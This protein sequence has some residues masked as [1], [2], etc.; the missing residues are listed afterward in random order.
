MKALQIEN[1]F[2]NIDIVYKECKKLKFYTKEE[3]PQN[4]KT[5][6]TKWPGKRTHELGQC[7]PLLKYF[8]TKYY[9][10]NNLITDEDKV[11]FYVHARFAGDDKEEWIHKDLANKSASL[12]YL[13]N[14]NLE[15]GTR[16]YSENEEKDEMIN[17]F[18]FVQNRLVMYSGTYPHRAYGSHGTTIDDCRLTLNVFIK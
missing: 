9:F 16:I 1:F 4:E 8:F 7:H 6:T 11:S 12:I 15:S 14:T 3:H 17:D 2:E 13:S 5:I 18:K 10:L